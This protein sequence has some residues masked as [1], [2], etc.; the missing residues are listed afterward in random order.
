MMEPAP[1]LFKT[2]V[3]CYEELPI[4]VF[5]KHRRTCNPCLSAA[6]L[7]R[8]K[9]GGEAERT[10]NREKTA[11]VRAVRV[12]MINEIKLKSGCVDCGFNSHPEALQFDHRDPK[13][14]SFAIA[15]NLTSSW[16]RLLDEIAK[17]DVR[18]ANC[19]VIR[20]VAEG[21]LGRPRK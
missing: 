21:H 15:K 18:C 17:C 14:K 8:Y 19:H 11:R 13:E 10:K 20:S 3:T 9:A 7:K 5:K 1:S 12:P 2:C 4:E 16:Q 6:Q